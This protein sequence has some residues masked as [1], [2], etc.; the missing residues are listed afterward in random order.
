MTGAKIKRV[1]PA[2]EDP[3]TDHL[4]DSYGDGTDPYGDGADDRAGSSQ[5]GPLSDEALRLVSAVQDWARRSFPQ[6][7]DEHVAGDCQWCPLCQF[8]AVLRGERPEVTERVA[9]AGTAV[10]S[11]LRALVDAASSAGGSTGQHRRPGPAPAPRVQRINLSDE[12]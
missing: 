5:P 8:V 6:A 12:S 4:D 7:D 2:K 3:L 1:Q 9:E 10:M 11:A